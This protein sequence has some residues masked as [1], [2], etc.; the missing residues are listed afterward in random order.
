MKG[1]L[2]AA[3]AIAVIAMPVQGAIYE[4]WVV[5]Q[6]RE[7]DEGVYARLAKEEG[8]WRLWRFETKYGVTCKAVK[9]ADGLP[10][11]IPLGVSSKLGLGTP[12]LEITFFD[13][14]R[15]SRIEGR[16]LGDQAEYR[17]PGERFWHEWSEETDLV[18]FL[19]SPSIEVHVSSW[20]YPAN[21]V[22]K[23]EER[24][25]INLSGLASIMHDGSEC[26]AARSEDQ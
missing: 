15:T 24:G 9:P 23:I 13:R 5:G 3:L 18:D 25:T 21:F 4:N 2:G 12:F 1:V 26:A 16:H 8:G 14:Q 22:G 19:E 17:S 6:E 20:K 7:V 10:A 11:P